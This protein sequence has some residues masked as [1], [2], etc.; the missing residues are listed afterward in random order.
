MEQRLFDIWLSLFNIVSG[1][2]IH[3]KR[4]TSEMGR[5]QTKPTR[6]TR[7]NYIKFLNTK[8]FFASPY[9]F[10]LT[11]AKIKSDQHCHSCKLE[12]SL[13]CNV[14]VKQHIYCSTLTVM[15]NLS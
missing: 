13:L 4:Q 7:T 12:T 14:V 5:N 8:Y 2:H 10:Y 9:T 3:W 15:S 11:L 1:L 6:L